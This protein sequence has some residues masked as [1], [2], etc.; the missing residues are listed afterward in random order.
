VRLE[1]ISMTALVLNCRLCWLRLAQYRTVLPSGAR[2]SGL[3]TPW[4]RRVRY[5]PG[6]Q[7]LRLASEAGALEWD[8]P[9]ASLVVK[10]PH[11]HSGSRWGGFL[12]YAW[13]GPWDVV[14]WALDESQE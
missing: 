2:P 10:A 9:V 14:G 4:L 6:A 13:S 8:R 3:S 1:V 11:A 5:A 12:T 7:R